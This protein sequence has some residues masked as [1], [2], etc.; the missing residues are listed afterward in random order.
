MRDYEQI[1][2]A[3]VERGH[4]SPKVDFK[5]ALE[6]R[7]KRTQATLARL[8]LAIANTDSDELDDVGYVIVGARRREIVGRCDEFGEDSFCA[9]LPTTLN[10]YIDPPAR[11]EIKGFEDPKV[12]WFGAIIVKPSRMMRPHLVAKEY[13]DAQGTVMRKDECYVRRGESVLFA[14]RSD[15]DRMYQ[16]RFGPELDRLLDRADPAPLPS[17]S[18][19]TNPPSEL[20]VVPPSVLVQRA[21]VGNETFSGEELAGLP[22][23]ARRRAAEHNQRVADYQA[24]VAAHT[25]VLDMLEDVAQN[26]QEVR[27]AVGNDGE[28]PLESAT[29]FLTFP[30]G[31]RLYDEDSLPKAPNL[32]KRPEKPSRM[33]LLGAFAAMEA[34][35]VSARYDVGPALEMSHLLRMSDVNPRSSGLELAGARRVEGWARKVGHGF[36]VTLRKA[37]VVIP[38]MHPGDYTVT[39]EVRADNLRRAHVGALTIRVEPGAPQVIRMKAAE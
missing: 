15:L 12:G 16:Q 4:E 2:R 8:V 38:P 24:A 27:V 37:I 28:A 29:V 25:D 39:T 30:E 22:E 11:V 19:A 33:S 20:V 35:F 7:A 13:T 1:A 17:V 3:L 32:P 18:W 9:S 5:E 26:G 21:D 10:N 6:L 14:G 36:S 31:F 34:A 23:A